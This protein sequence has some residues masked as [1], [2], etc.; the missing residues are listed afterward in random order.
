M[1]LFKWGTLIVMCRKIS[2]LLAQNRC[3][4]VNAITEQEYKNIMKISKEMIVL[5]C[6]NNM[7]KEKN[8][9]NKAWPKLGVWRGSYDLML[10]VSFQI[11][12]SP[13]KMLP[14]NSWDHLK[15]DVSRVQAF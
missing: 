3:L 2:A 11:V 6:F 5:P 9:F 1:C 14:V 15:Q 7:D 13:N 4:H 10:N 12:I 8:F